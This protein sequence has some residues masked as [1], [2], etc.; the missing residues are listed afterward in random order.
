MLH[1]TLLPGRAASAAAL[2]SALLA[3]TAFAGPDWDEPTFGD[4]G[5]EAGTAQI[6]TTDGSVN[7][8]RGK[9]GGNGL[10]AGD[11]QDLFV[12]NIVDP[13]AFSI[14]TRLE[15][16][17]FAD[18]NPMLFLFR[19]DGL[20][21]GAKA[22]ALL[23]NDDFSANSTAAR[24]GSQ[25]NDGSGAAV[26]QAGLYVIGISGFASFPLNDF[27]ESLFGTKLFETGLVVGPD[28]GLNGVT[29]GGW[30]ADG[31]A[32]EYVIRITGATGV[33]IPAPGALALLGC[34][35][36]VRRRRR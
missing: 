29:L 7:T 6:I 33:A 25:S 24:I 17:G 9:L 11:F 21:K 28:G 8:I 26:T 12:V 5:N 34:A 2:S 15:D 3:S 35:G 31:Q 23:G 4:A 27:G 16:G 32:G 20:G 22:E 10:L 14:S 1:R 36:L 18:F 13:G 19:L 30:S